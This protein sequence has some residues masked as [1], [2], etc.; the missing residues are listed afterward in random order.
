M[1]HYLNIRILL[2]EFYEFKSVG[3]YELDWAAG[4]FKCDLSHWIS[5]ALLGFLQCLNIFWMYH[6]VRIAIRFVWYKVA[7]DDR[8]DDD[9]TELAEEKEIERLKQL[10]IDG[11][12]APK[13]LVNGVAIGQG[14]TS[15]ADIKTD[16]LTNRKEYAS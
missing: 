3:P 4:Q 15:G 5:T 13:L 2:S 11:V 16:S 1:R 8:S 12:A 14:K 10:G 7:E 6:I 9:E